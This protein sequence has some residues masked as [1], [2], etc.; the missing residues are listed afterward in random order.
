MNHYRV[1]QVFVCRAI[2]D[3]IYDLYVY[4]NAKSLDMFCLG[5]SEMINDFFF[6][7]AKEG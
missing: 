1:L 4:F 3:L 2:P 7:F 6:F 5:I